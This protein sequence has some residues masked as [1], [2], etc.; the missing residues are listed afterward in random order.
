MTHECVYGKL[1]RPVT[2]PGGG[3][4]LCKLK[5]GRKKRS[6]KTQL[7]CKK[8]R[9][10]KPP[11]C[12][13]QKGCEWEVGKGCRAVKDGK[14][15]K[16]RCQ[17]YRK[18]K[19]PKCDNQKGC[20]WE[21]GK[22][23]QASQ[24]KKSTKRKSLLLGKIKSSVIK[25]LYQIAY[26]TCRI[27]EANG[28]KVWADSGTLL[29][30]IRNKGI[31][32]WDDD[33]DLGLLLDDESRF[34]S[35]KSTFKKCGYTILKVWFGYKI[36]PLKAKKIPGHKWGYPFLDCFFYKKQKTG[37]KYLLASKEARDTWPK[38]YYKEKELFPLKLNPFGDFLIPVCNKANI[39]L[40]RRYGSDWLTHGYREY[41]HAKEEGIKPVKVK[42]SKAELEPAKPT[43]VA[44]RKCMG[45]T[46]LTKEKL[47]QQIPLRK[48]SGNCT[49]A[50][51]RGC[52]VR[53]G[54]KKM[55]IFVINCDIHT[56]RIKKFRK[57]AAEAA[58]PICREVCVNGKAFDKDMLCGMVSNN[59]LIKK[60][61]MTPIEVSIC[62]SHINVWQR[63]VDS[64]QS[65]ALVLEDDAEVHKNFK[66]MLNKTLNALRDKGK[67]FDILYLWNGNWADTSE[68]TKPV[69]KINDKINVL[70][71]TQEFNAGAVAYVLSQKFAKSLLKNVYPIE[72]P[73]DLYMGE[74]ALARGKKAYTIEMSYNEKKGCYLSPFFRGTKW[75]CGGSEGTGATTQ[76]YSA[77]KIKS[78]K[79][80]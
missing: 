39:I 15:P 12:D 3:K 20:E 45:T 76:N 17:K 77:K 23:C 29:G 11:K 57:Y 73:I 24:G 28:I 33:V 8:Y 4:R 75:I 70:Q 10:T 46:P 71:E 42:L 80:K 69:L 35:L 72:E 56:K 6:S 63:F 27:L 47:R 9:K 7:H 2:L 30:A 36:F 74:Q 5:P 43:K 44:N 55:P 62:Y 64:C 79:C 59:L 22:G 16:P 51:S 31:I 49:S 1:A 19:S 52:E 40:K 68:H 34:K 60:A 32:P 48:A 38:D 14:S 58:L 66:K 61:D 67:H 13:N 54:G 50:T 37:D 78:I 53:L 18:T 65:Y 26:D 21:V 25:K 41:D